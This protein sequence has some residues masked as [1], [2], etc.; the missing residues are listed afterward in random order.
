MATAILSAAGVASGAV[1]PGAATLAPDL[2]VLPVQQ[3]DLLLSRERGE[4]VLRFTTEIANRGSGPSR[5]FRALPRR[6]ATATATTRTTATPRSACSTTR[7]PTAPSTSGSTPCTPSDASGACA[8]TRHTRT[9][10]CWPWPPTSCAASRAAL[11]WRPIARS[12]TAS[13]DNRLAFPGPETPRNAIYP[14]GPPGSM[15][16]DAAATE[17]ISVGWSDVYGLALPEPGP[18]DHRPGA[19]PLLPRR[20]RRSR[21]AARGERRGRQRPPYRPAASPGRRAGAQAALPL[22]PVVTRR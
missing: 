19:R 21:S 13:G 3:E 6:T 17:G 15:G 1:A 7:T 9:G 22:S 14:F 2:V 18:P 10:T 12:A 4:I 11:P 16:C 20:P 8:S 5:S